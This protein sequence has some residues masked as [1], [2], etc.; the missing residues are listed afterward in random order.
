MTHTRRHFLKNSAG[1]AA[2]AALGPYASLGAPG[3]R[4]AVAPEGGAGAPGRK[5]CCLQIGPDCFVDEGIEPVLYILQEKGAVDTLYLSTFTYDRGIIGRTWG[6]DFPGHGVDVSDKG[7]FH[8]GNYAT[9]H[10]KFYTGTAIKGERLK[11]PDF[12]DRDMLAEVLS[13]TKRR[14]IK[15]ICSIQDGF[16]YPADMP[17]IAGMHEIDLQ[18]RKGDAL[19]F[20]NPD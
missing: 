4:E 7:Y 18:G 8:G 6:K 11:A 2:L 14:G 10:A 13:K 15:V 5:S 16:S 3:M 12:G 20:F 9:P 19:C 1:V 17:F